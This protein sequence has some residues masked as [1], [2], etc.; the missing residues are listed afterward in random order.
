MCVYVG[1]C[2]SFIQGHL[3]KSLK[4][5]FEQNPE[6]TEGASLVGP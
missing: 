5:R 3:Q 1:V 4:K 2:V 6:G